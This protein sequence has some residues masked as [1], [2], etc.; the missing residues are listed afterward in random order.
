MV[1]GMERVQQL[2]A[3]ICDKITGLSTN[4]VTPSKQE[5]FSF[6]EGTLITFL[7]LQ[8]NQANIDKFI[9]KLMICDEIKLKNFRHIRL[10]HE[11]VKFCHNTYDNLK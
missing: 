4:F 10:S 2:P 1:L 7:Q 11:G 3:S 9:P 8:L 6:L 5:D